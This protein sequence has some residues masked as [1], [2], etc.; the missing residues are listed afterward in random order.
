MDGIAAGEQPLGD[1]TADV[2]RATSYQD[3]HDELRIIIRAEA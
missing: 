3:P 2:P 1:H